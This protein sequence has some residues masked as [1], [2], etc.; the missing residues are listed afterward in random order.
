MQ[1]MKE[2]DFQ[3]MT[4]DELWA[5]RETITS[6]LSTKMMAEKLKLEQHLDD[7]HRRFGAVERATA[8]PNAGRIRR[9]Q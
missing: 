8:A 4:T 6:I 1:A 5:L 2:I 7:L 9:S 3:S